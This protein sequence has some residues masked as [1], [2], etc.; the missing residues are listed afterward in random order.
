MKPSSVNR[1]LPAETRGR[2]A[3]GRAHEPIDDPGLAA[4]FGGHP[5]GRGGDVGKGQR[6]HQ[7][8]EQRLAF[9]TDRPRHSDQAHNS[10]SRISKVPMPT[11]M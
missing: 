4:Q 5:S 7:S 8:P 3:I 11:M 10:M 1:P 6:Q 9:D 2:N